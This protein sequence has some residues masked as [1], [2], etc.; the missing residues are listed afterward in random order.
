MFHAFQKLNIVDFKSFDDFQ[1][2]SNVECWY[3]PG[4]EQR[5]TLHGAQGGSLVLRKGVLSNHLWII[6]SPKSGEKSEPFIIPYSKILWDEFFDV[7]Y[8]TREV[9]SIP[10]IK[11]TAS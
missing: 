8:R 7:A 2:L 1:D 4:G 5:V 3:I 9:R 10:A 6:W 11:I